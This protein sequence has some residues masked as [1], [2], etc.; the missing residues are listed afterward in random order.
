MRKNF[1]ESGSWNV[2]CD[3]CGKRMKSSHAK[4]RW[5]GF[6]VCDGC[7][8]HR[9]PQDF[10][11]TKPD[12]QSVPYSRPPQD[13]F[14]PISYAIETLTCT[15]MSSVAIPSIAVCGCVVAGKQ[16]HGKL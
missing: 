8:E 1:F 13:T 3:S 12:K 11:R 5:D 14:I 7:F 4:H 16:L 15:P 2:I 10:I 6:I 9:H